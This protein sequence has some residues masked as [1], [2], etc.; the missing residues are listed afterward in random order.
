MAFVIC[1]GE[2]MVELFLSA[3][4]PDTAQI[5]YAGDTLNTAIYLKRALPDGRV[6]FA[7]KLGR[8]AFS[9]QMRRMITDEGLE[10]DLLLE[11]PDREPGLYSITTDRDG[12]RSFNYWRSASAARDLLTPPALTPAHLAPADMVYLS[13]IS[14]AILPAQDRH[15]LLGWLE[16]FRANGGRV[17]FD[18][19]YRPKLWEDVE[20]ARAVVT[21]AWKLTDIALPS[22]DDEMALFG[23]PDE[24]AVLDRLTACGLNQG[25]LKRGAIGPR[26]L[27]GSRPGDFEAVT[28]VVDS[29]AAGDSFN[30]GYL[31][32]HLSGAPQAA[33]LQAGH[34]LASRV[35]G[36][37]GAIIPREE[38][39]T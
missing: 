23:D 8:D 7:S 33:C 10:T 29:T 6:A 15:T 5:G 13:A 2:A 14:L 28:K 38:A 1:L 11:S 26:S 16:D 27:D 37:R 17:A 18:S 22:L 9:N 32:A 3:T 35:I 30:A 36:M 34:R 21:K 31:A 4:S 24:G 39:M 19:N 20:T 12:E 25:A